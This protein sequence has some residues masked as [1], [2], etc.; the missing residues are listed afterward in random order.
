MNATLL[1]SDLAAHSQVETKGPP[2]KK[3]IEISKGAIM[4]Q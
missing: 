2:I 1:D 4:A 3:A